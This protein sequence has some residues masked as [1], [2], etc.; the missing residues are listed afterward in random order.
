MS[1][2]A[3][4]AKPAQAKPTP[5][6]LT[7]PQGAALVNVGVTRFQEI[8][9]TDPSFPA[10]IWLGPRGKRHAKSELLAWALSKRRRV[11]NTELPAATASEAA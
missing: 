4:R 7:D 11:G 1:R 10:P 6:L 8:Q 5:E 3:K 2:H 9:K